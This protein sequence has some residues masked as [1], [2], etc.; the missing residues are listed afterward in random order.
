MSG[1]G[2]RRMRPV[3]QNNSAKKNTLF[4]LLWE[5]FYNNTS[6]H[7]FSGDKGAMV[8][9]MRESAQPDPFPCITIK[10]WPNGKGSEK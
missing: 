4:D 3:N 5:H 7:L 8:L 6:S 1:A 10:V 9:E 2:C